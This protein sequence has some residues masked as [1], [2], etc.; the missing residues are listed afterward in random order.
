M[1]PCVQ[2][3]VTPTS[4]YLFK[5]WGGALCDFLSPNL[6][7]VTVS[8][9]FSNILSVS[10]PGTQAILKKVV[11]VIWFERNILLKDTLEY[12]ALMEDTDFVHQPDVVLKHLPRSRNTMHGNMNYEVL[13][14]VARIRFALSIASKSL[15]NH[16][17]QRNTN[18]VEGIQRLMTMINK[19]WVELKEVFDLR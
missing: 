7:L 4:T 16:F 18:S 5:G 3:L 11:N 8:K 2:I 13:D 17:I 19:L 15:F 1:C 10:K 12:H 6:S 14:S 9:G